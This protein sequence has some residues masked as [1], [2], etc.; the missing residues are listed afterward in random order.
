MCILLSSN[1]VTDAKWFQTVFLIAQDILIMHY[2]SNC[3][4]S[5]CGSW[6]THQLQYYF[7]Y[8][9]KKLTGFDYLSIQVLMPY[10]AKCNEMT[11]TN[12]V[13]SEYT[14]PLFPPV[15]VV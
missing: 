1:L 2:A 10:I 13:L 11:K 4:G 14:V 6:Q 15:N 3:S 12:T 7:K 9:S 5:R 8:Y